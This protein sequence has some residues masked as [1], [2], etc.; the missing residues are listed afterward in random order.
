MLAPH[1]CDNCGLR[2]LCDGDSHEARL[3][4]PTQTVHQR[5]AP[6]AAGDY[7]SWEGERAHALYAVRSG[8]LK[9]MSI[10]T[11]GNERVRAFHM[12]GELIGLDS[13]HTGVHMSNVESLTDSD[14]CE[15]PFSRLD[16]ALAN[17]PALRRRLFELL[18]LNLAAALN[19][20]GDYSADQRI[21]AFLLDMAGRQGATQSTDVIRFE[22]SRRD[23]ANYLRLVTETVS[24]VLTRMRN[25]NVIAV[26]RRQLHVLDFEALE[27]MAGPLAQTCNHASQQRRA[28]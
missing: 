17:V 8:V 3:T 22:M 25:A 20:G 14:V 7:L 21:A 2:A 23:I 28:A 24:R 27:R 9:S 15:L 5:R 1:S 4:A 11:E 13:F 10:D 6:L 18:S 19:L 26:N 16:D 12:P